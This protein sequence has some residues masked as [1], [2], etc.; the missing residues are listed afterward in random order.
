MENKYE[1][2]TEAIE[3]AGGAPAVA[4]ECGLGSYQAVNKWKKHGIPQS[5]YTGK[6]TYAVTL[7]R[8]TGFKYTF[9]QLLP[10]KD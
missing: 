6:T 10:Q 9:G 7:R 3:A 5:D 4:R 8:L 1:K 2:L